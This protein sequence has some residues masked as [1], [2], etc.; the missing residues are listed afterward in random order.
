MATNSLE[1]SP[2]RHQIISVIYT[3]YED[4]MKTVYDKVVSML[5]HCENGEIIEQNDWLDITLC[6]VKFK[7]CGGHQLKDFISYIT[8]EVK[9]DDYTYYVNLLT[10]IKNCPLDNYCEI[11][12]NK[13]INS[14]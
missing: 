7:V 11:I 6:T 9:Y 5:D 14:I 13:F 10:L 4:T 12:K 1:I 3:N 2:I 8:W